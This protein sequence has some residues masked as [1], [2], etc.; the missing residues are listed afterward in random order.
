MHI[1]ITFS[2]AIDPTIL[3]NNAIT[4][5]AIHNGAA[6]NI[7]IEDFNSDVLQKK[8]VWQSINIKSANIRFHNSTLNRFAV[9]DAK[10]R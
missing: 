5:K 9:F 3:N 2:R 6:V 4:R 7:I 10:M 1:T 8:Q